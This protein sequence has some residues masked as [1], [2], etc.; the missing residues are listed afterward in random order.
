MAEDGRP[1]EIKYFSRESDL[2]LT[3]G[4]LVDTSG[5]MRRIIEPERMASYKFFDQ[6]LREDKDKGVPDPFR[7]RGGV[8]AGSDVVAQAAATALMNRLPRRHGRSCSS[9]V[10]PTY[11]G[12]AGAAG[13][14]RN[15][16]V[17]CDPAGLDELMKKQTGRKAIILLTDGEDNGSHSHHDRRHRCRATRR[18]AVLHHSIRDESSSQTD[19][20]FRRAWNGTAQRRRTASDAASHATARRCSSASPR[21]PAADISKRQ[22]EVARR[23]LSPDSGRTA[24]PVQP[25]L[26][27]TQ[28]RSRV[29]RHRSHVERKI[30]H[31]ASPQRLLPY[32]I[33]N[34]LF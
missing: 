2:P 16:A 10:T 27:S 14:R 11:P 23:Y 24:Q 9:A 21:K 31:R 34:R 29:P 15:G 17:R 7:F 26:H 8:V 3:L 25:G 28:Q 18:H 30:L 32:K 4:L 20:R 33:I 19:R 1:M 6:V 12:Q 13:A 5:S 22:E